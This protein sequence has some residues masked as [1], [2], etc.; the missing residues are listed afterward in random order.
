MR[1]VILA[2]GIG[3][4]FAHP[5][6]KVLLSF[7]GETLLARHL[8]ILDHCG[9]ER[10]DMCVGYCAEDIT[11]ELARLGAAE[12][13]RLHHNPDFAQGS[14][15][16]LWTVGS[17]LTA[18]DTVVFMDGDVL[19]DHRLLQRLIAAAPANCFLMDRN[20][21]PGDEPVRLCLRDGRLVD[22]RKCP[23]VAHDEAGEWI[24]FARFTP[25]TAARIAAAAAGRVEAG[26]R[27][28]VYEEAFCDVL[29]A[30]TTGSF[31]IED[32][33]GLPW[34]EIDFA[35]D[36]E[37]AERDVFPRLMALPR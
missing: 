24:G 2:A 28:E 9:I 12:R 3:R 35:D 7:G 6:P 21:R 15:V 32:V 22:I 29:V 20:L 8:C 17:V 19:Y 26:R 13:V 31:G 16:S 11:A 4:R 37:T 34:I 18:G 36:L 27:D 5:L 10:V 33:T 30:D 25:E 1:A 14:I 23:K